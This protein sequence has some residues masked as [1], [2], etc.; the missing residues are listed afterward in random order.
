MS[1]VFDQVRN[2]STFDLATAALKGPGP[3]ATDQIDRALL[4]AWL[5]FADGSIGWTQQVDTN[6]DG[7][8]D[9]PF[10]QVMTNAERVRLD[11]T[12]SASTLR[13]QKAILETVT[14]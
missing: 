4:T 1:R 6:G 2:V 10:S 3:A 8:P 9:T 5:D 12:S 7:T 14:G 11:K 13:T